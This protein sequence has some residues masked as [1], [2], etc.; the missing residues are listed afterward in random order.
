MRT[1]D[2][3]AG[4]TVHQVVYRWGGRN[5]L[6]SAGIGP[7]A[8]SGER[9]RLEAIHR[10]VAPSLRVPGEA[11]RES[12]AR[13]VLPKELEPAGKVLLIRRTPVTDPSGRPSTCCHALFGS[14]RVLTP[15][16]CLRLYPWR[17]PGGDAFP[18]E[19]EGEALAPVPVA[20]LGRAAHGVGERL[21][22]AV[23][24][25]RGELTAL[26]A[27]ALRRPDHRLSLLDR[28]GGRAPLPLLWGAV[29]ILQGLLRGQW[30]FA[31]HDTR[32]SGPFRFVFVPEWPESAADDG[33]LHR[34]DLARSHRHDQAHTAAEE[35]V[36]HHLRI[37]RDEEAVRHTTHRLREYVG[38]LDRHRLGDQLFEVQQTLALLRRGGPSRP[39]TPAPRASAA[40]EPPREREPRTAPPDPA[41]APYGGPG[42][43]ADRV[44]P[45]AGTG[46]APGDRERRAGDDA[47]LRRLEAGAQ[48]E[49]AVA[50]LRELVNG[51]L[52]R[53]GAEREEV[54]RTVLSADLYVDRLR[55]ARVGEAV[56]V[57]RTLVRPCV[58]D[59]RLAAQLARTLPRLWS[60]HGEAGRE[61]VRRL[62]DDPSPTGF[63]EQ[64]WKALFRETARYGSV[65]AAASPSPAASSLAAS[66]PTPSSSA[67]PAPR[68]PDRP[69]VTGRPPATAAPRPAPTPPPEPR[70]HGLRSHEP[71][72]HAARS[73]E[74][75][76]HAPR[77]HVPDHA[78]RSHAPRDQGPPVAEP[79][80]R[81]SRGD[82]ADRARPP[83]PR[84]R[85]WRRAPR[86]PVS[87]VVDAP[88][89]SRHAGQVWV[90][91]LLSVLVVAVVLIIVL[92]AS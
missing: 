30:S 27:E 24:E 17:W 16:L 33:L 63:G 49:D 31:T 66:S 73:H 50:A 81:G 82:P 10:Y 35:L 56:E 75:S 7:A 86:P 6:G 80:G 25:F 47:P 87:D 72:G 84:R 52:L 58:G 1:T 4:A 76:S 13:L 83:G 85:W 38:P 55:P 15:D 77:D 9:D 90:I 36:A 79:D 44:R 43:D 64:G 23:E 78:P 28:T 69:V 29:R 91:L 11:A 19:A 46:V 54:C 89:P 12:I 34:V 48:G 39:G 20:A 2:G 53:S 21:G 71:R 62:V 40:T 41:R 8:W 65:P 74:P 5:A 18:W 67:P 92:A 61:V 45:G 88:E 26:V 22:E 42:H 59:E 60:R 32:D 3:T 14:G 37:R 57:Y 51:D 70:G 68:S